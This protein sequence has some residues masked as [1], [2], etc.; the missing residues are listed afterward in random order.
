[1]RRQKKIAKGWLL[2]M[3]FIGWVITTGIFLNG[4]STDKATFS[5]E[6]EAKLPEKIDFNYI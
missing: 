2:L 5:Q 1:M 6:I 3:A 4:C